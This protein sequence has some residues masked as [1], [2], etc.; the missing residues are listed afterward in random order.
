M[1]GIRKLP[2]FKALAVATT[3]LGLACLFLCFGYPFSSPY[4]LQKITLLLLS[5]LS[6]TAA[7][8]LMEKIIH[9]DPIE[10]EIQS[11]E[12]RAR[13]S[14]D[15]AV[16][17]SQIKQKWAMLSLEQQ[18]RFLAE[19]TQPKPLPPLANAGKFIEASYRLEQGEPMDVV[20]TQIWKVEAGTR[21][22]ASIRREFETWLNP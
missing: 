1:P 10:T 4:K 21:D 5:I 8:I 2:N 3:T 19:L 9:N 13:R 7:I 16:L 12:R 22:H 17:L 11:I 20:V 14:T 18:Q 15:R 6:S